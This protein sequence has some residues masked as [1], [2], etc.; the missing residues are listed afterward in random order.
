MQFLHMSKNTEEEIVSLPARECFG[1]LH[2]V[3]LI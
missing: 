2:G 1:L 3:I